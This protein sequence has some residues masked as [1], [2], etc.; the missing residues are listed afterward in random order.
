[1]V[2]SL[3]LVGL[4]VP[5]NPDEGACG[6]HTVQRGS[7]FYRFALYVLWRRIL[8]REECNL[9][10]TRALG[11][12]L[13]HAGYFGPAAVQLEMNGAFSC[14]PLS[15]IMRYIYSYHELLGVCN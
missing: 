4:S 6:L 13:L 12:I 9:W 15:V 10:F 5:R 8:D 2:V 1:M 7:F 14:G 11:N 3:S